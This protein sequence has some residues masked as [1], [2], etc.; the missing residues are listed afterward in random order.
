MCS[1]AC[2]PLSLSH[3][4]GCTLLFL[5]QAERWG[6]RLETEDVVSVDLSSRPF[7]VR[8]T[9]TTVKA[10][11]VIVATVRQRQRPQGGRGAVRCILS[12]L[13][14]APRC[15]TS[16]A[17]AAARAAHLTAG[18]HRQ[19]AEPAQRA[20]LLVQRHLRLR[21]LRRRVHHLQAAGERGQAWRPGWP[22]PHQWPLDVRGGVQPWGALEATR[23]VQ[24]ACRQPSAAACL[25]LINVLLPLLARPLWIGAQLF[26]STRGG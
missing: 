23:R 11:S 24:L 25:P 26:N 13:C 6:A 12:V 10:H 20:A 22:L 1:G 8:G 17:T 5:L 15:R 18:R 7:T 19:E 14:A 9:D 16:Q 2:A 4:D 3:Q 21:H